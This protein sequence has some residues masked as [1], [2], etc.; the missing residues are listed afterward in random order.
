MYLFVN[1]LGFVTG[2]VAVARLHFLFFELV[3]DRQVLKKAGDRL[4]DTASEFV[5]MFDDALG[6]G[7]VEVEL[8]KGLLDGIGCEA[9]DLFDLTRCRG[10]LSNRIHALSPFGVTEIARQRLIP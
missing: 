1:T 6:A 9:A 3:G 8:C 2:E 7:L 10:F 4:A 5:S